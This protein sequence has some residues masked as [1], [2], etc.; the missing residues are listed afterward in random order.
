M[1]TLRPY[2]LWLLFVVWMGVGGFQAVQYVREEIAALTPAQVESALSRA[3]P[4]E[5]AE[6]DVVQYLRGCG[7][8]FEVAGDTIRATVPWPAS[9][10]AHPITVQFDL[11]K[12]VV[13]DRRV[14]LAPADGPPL[15]EPE[16][17]SVGLVVAMLMGAS[18]WA[19][20]RVAASAFGASRGPA[21][22]RAYCTA[23]GSALGAWA[24]LG[25]LRLVFV[26]CGLR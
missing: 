18:C 26:L 8:P 24:A 21:G 9:A 13:T 4:G 5:P 11:E 25:Y 16:L 20:W 1:R 17:V 19:G 3:L 22:G 7:W 15:T 23:A 12:G 6:A 14:E 2:L 10:P